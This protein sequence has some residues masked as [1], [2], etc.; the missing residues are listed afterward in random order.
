MAKQSSSPSPP[1]DFLWQEL[2][3]RSF[4]Q[5]PLPDSTDEA[6][7]PALPPDEDLREHLVEMH[8]MAADEGPQ[9]DHPASPRPDCPASPDRPYEPEEG[10]VRRPLRDWERELEFSVS[11]ENDDDDYYDDCITEDSDSEPDFAQGRKIVTKSTPEVITLDAST[12]TTPE[13]VVIKT[14]LPS[15]P[16]PLAPIVTLDERQPTPEL[17]TIEVK[18]EPMLESPFNRPA[19]P[20]RAGPSWQPTTARLTNTTILDSQQKRIQHQAAEIRQ[21][22]MELEKLQREIS[23]EEKK[24]QRAIEQRRCTAGVIACYDEWQ[25]RCRLTHAKKKK[26]Q[27]AG[28]DFHDAVLAL[29]EIQRRDAD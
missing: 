23:A 7:R 17:V 20:N 15:M 24:K 29:F 4:P 16:P 22:R 19:T 9:P 1:P 18:T 11:D 12:Q 21:A 5:F 28:K 2:V 10:Y 14:P 8:A 25:R 13:P 27:A 26:E 6:D 3:E